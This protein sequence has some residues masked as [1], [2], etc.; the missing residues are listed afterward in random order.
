M[1]GLR[2]LNRRDSSVEQALH[3]G[4]V[5]GE[6]VSTMGVTLQLHLARRIIMAII[7]YRPAWRSG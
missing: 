2:P 4:I 3:S 1:V 7:L 5:N 6:A